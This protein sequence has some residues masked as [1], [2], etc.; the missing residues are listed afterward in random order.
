[1][2]ISFVVGIS[3][4]NIYSCKNENGKNHA[5]NRQGSNCHLLFHDI[6]FNRLR[7]NPHF[8]TTL[9]FLSPIAS[10][11]HS[12]GCWRRNETIHLSS[13]LLLM[14]HATLPNSAGLLLLLKFLRQASSQSSFP[15]CNKNHESLR[16]SLM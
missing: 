6:Q 9:F 7:N 3:A 10:T 13:M 16:A 8:D 15:C 4:D 12:P 5:A 1:M 11:H 2:P 14:F